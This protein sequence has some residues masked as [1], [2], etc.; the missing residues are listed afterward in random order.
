[1]TMPSRQFLVRQATI[2]YTQRAF[3]WMV[4]QSSV[5]NV[6]KRITVDGHFLANTPEIISGIQNEY[7][8][9][10]IREQLCE[11]GIAND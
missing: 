6:L 7:R 2:N 1:M 3:P 10:Y 5:G 9:L 4:S 8:A 11:R